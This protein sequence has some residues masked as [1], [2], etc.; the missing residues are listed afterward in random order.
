VVGRLRALAGQ[1]D[2]PIVPLYATHAA[3]LTARDGE[4]LDALVASFEGIGAMLLAAE[5][6]VEAAVAH[7]T[8]HHEQA[9]RMSAA[10][11]SALAG[12]CE[13]ARTPA[14]RLL[15]MPPQLT[16][17]EREITGMVASGLSN[18]VI[19][20]RLVLSVRTVDNHLQHA[21]DKLGI[22]S[23][24]ELRSVVGAASTPERVRQPE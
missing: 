22:R 9:G 23:R 14:L 18:R 5:V 4:V 11:A 21:F 7:R 17:R 10:R 15:D 6:A 3:A 16:P 24:R 12:R 2:S 13:G 1:V 20:E 8:A 19:A